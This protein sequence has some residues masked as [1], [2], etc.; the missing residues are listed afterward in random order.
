MTPVPATVV[1]VD[2]YVP[3][4]LVGEFFHRCCRV[5]DEQIALGVQSYPARVIELAEAGTGC[6]GPAT[7]V[8]ADA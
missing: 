2:A 7:T 6:A 3:V 4:A 5:R 8:P 1:A